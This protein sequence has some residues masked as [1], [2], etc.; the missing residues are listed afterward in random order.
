VKPIL[1]TWARHW[2]D[3][4]AWGRPLEEISVRIVGRYNHKEPGACDKFSTGTA[5]PTKR[6]TV[7]RA[8]SDLPDALA[9]ILHEYAHLAAPGG[10]AHGLPWSSRFAAAVLEVTRIAICD[11]GTKGEVDRAATAA[12]RSWWKSSGNAFAA[13]LLQ[14]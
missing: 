12:V 10:A 13:G 4:R 1:E 2:R 5:W 7:I 9:T 8:G 11:D 14:R 6:D 3:L